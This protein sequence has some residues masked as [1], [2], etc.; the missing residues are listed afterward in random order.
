[1]LK[2]LA[3]IMDGNRR[4]SKSLKQR[5]WKGHNYGAEKMFEVID[6]CFESKIKI[7]TLYAFSYE[8]FNRSKSEFNHLMRIFDEK[9]D[10]IENDMKKIHERGVQVNFVGRYERFPEKVKR[11]MQHLMDVTRSNQKFIINFAMAYSGRVE[12]VDAVKRIVQTGIKEDQIN[13]KS[14]MDNLYISDE[15]DLIIRTGGEKRLSN[16][17]TY[18]SV[19]SELFF[20]NTLWP[21]FSKEEFLSILERFKKRNRR[22]GR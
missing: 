3:V 17:L 11:K 19:Y 22:F 16:F 18:Q 5:A 7:L 10:K 1:M 9:L 21:E 14:I 20:T 6:W 8:N 15:P 4:Y 12:I 13:E 2:H